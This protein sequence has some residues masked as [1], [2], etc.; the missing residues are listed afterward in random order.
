MSA[1]FAKSLTTESAFEYF[2]I[3]HTP[4]SFFQEVD[5]AQMGPSGAGTHCTP[6]K[7]KA[8]ME[9]TASELNP[10][11]GRISGFIESLRPVFEARV[12]GS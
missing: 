8:A 7:Q 10:F 12:C 2:H 3:S 6:P 9:L 1:Q 5:E 4:M 11:S